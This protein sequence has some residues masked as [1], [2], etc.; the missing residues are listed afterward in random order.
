MFNCWIPQSSLYVIVA[1]KTAT[2]VEVDYPAKQVRIGLR[3]STSGQA[4]RIFPTSGAWSAVRFAYRDAEGR[5]L[6]AVPSMRLAIEWYWA[7][8]LD[9]GATVCADHP[10]GAQRCAFEGDTDRVPVVTVSLSLLSPLEFR[11]ACGADPPPGKWV[12][13]GNV[14][15]QLAFGISWDDT[16]ASLAGRDEREVIAGVEVGDAGP[17][18]DRSTLRVR[19][20]RPCF[21]PAST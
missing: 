18:I 15:K 20:G 17:V 12:L 6:D 7:V 21:V 1:P 13:V 14:V 8:A 2:E 3:S 16:R 10:L 19:N 4:G 5:L 11:R 9:A